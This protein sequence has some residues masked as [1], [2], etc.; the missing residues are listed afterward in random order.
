MAGG[1]TPGGL[2]SPLRSTRPLTAGPDKIY[3]VGNTLADKVGTWFT[4]LVMW[5]DLCKHRSSA[6]QT[7]KQTLEEISKGVAH[8]PTLTVSSC[9][10]LLFTG[11]RPLLEWRRQSHR[12]G[13]HLD[14][15]RCVP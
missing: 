1:V 8:C 11:G 12:L 4:S 15:C 7:A 3:D 2:S 6:R 5:S 14:L 10:A 13:Q 9:C